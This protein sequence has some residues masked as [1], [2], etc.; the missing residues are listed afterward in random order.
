MVL[1]EVRLDIRPGTPPGSYRLMLAFYDPTDLERLRVQ[2]EAGN[3]LPDQ[4]LPLH[5]IVLNP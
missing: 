2:D 3:S 1:D 5:D 4:I